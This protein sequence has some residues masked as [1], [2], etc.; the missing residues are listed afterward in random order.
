MKKDKK[1]MQ[2]GLLVSGPTRLSREELSEY[3]LKERNEEKRRA[4][5]EWLSLQEKLEFNV[6]FIISNRNGDEIYIRL[7]DA[8]LNVNLNF[9]S[10]FDNGSPFLVFDKNPRYMP[11]RLPMWALP[12]DL[13][14]RPLSEEAYDRRRKYWE[15]R[16]G[17]FDEKNRQFSSYGNG[18]VFQILNIGS[19]G[20]L[21]TKREILE[22]SGWKP[23]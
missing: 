21:A 14:L 17:P 23:F 18:T 3:L 13:K 7:A 11:P 19:L 6:S 8:S 1:F 9:M 15:R 16:L 5:T 4:T 10:P 12:T 20:K 22:E 2:Y